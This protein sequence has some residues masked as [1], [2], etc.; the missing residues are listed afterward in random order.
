LK[1]LLRVG[2]FPVAKT[3]KEIVKVAQANHGALRPGSEAEKR[4]LQYEG[5]DLSVGGQEA[6][7][8]PLTDKELEIA[9]SFDKFDD[10]P[11]SGSRSPSRK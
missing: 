7:K 8:K 2:M 10:S 6:G 9:G 3:V 11:D 1:S 5:L 4:L